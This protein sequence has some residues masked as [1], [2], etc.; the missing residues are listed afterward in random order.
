[1]DNSR[2]APRMRML[3]SGKIMIGTWGVPCAIKNLS[4]TGACLEVQTTY[5]IP[6]AFELVMPHNRS[7]TCK[8]IWLDRTKLGVQFK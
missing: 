3:Q 8:V 7:E 1:M 6:A 2:K 4:E 5:G